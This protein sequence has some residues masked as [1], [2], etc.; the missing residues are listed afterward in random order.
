MLARAE[1]SGDQHREAGFMKTKSL[2]ALLFL[3]VALSAQILP[4]TT[5]QNSAN[6]YGQWPFRDVG[7]AVIFPKMICFETGVLAGADTCLFRDSQGHIAI[8]NGAGTTQLGAPSQT[9]GTYQG[10]ASV[11]ITDTSF[12][13]LVAASSDIQLPGG[14]TGGTA[15]T[16]SK[17]GKLVRIHADGVYTNAA[18][19]LLNVEAMLCQVSGCASGT[20]VAPA[21]CTVTTTNQANNLTN[22][23]WTLDCTLTTAT[24][25]AAGTVM[26]K[27]TLCAN[28]GAAT[29][30]AL[31]CFAD[32]ATAVSAA[33]DLTVPEF[34]NVA[35]KFSTSNGGNSATLHDY[36]V[37]VMN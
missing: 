31:S 35:F 23:Q 34:I 21:G 4:P 15:G 27:S 30:A 32:T 8:Y 36:A 33:I 14:T 7:N 17:A 13:A 2:I 16:I 20:V 5:T 11:G 9:L 19:S 25:G 18:A 29:S 26:A 1:V 12:H 24:T 3:S 6:G 28:L 37:E 22:G 10:T